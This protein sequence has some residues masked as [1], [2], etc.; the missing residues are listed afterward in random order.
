MAWSRSFCCCALSP[1]GLPLGNDQLPSVD[2]ARLFLDFYKTYGILSSI[3]IHGRLCRIGAALSF[4]A[5]SL[6]R[7]LSYKK[8][9]AMVHMSDQAGT[10]RRSR[11]V[12]S[13]ALSVAM[14]F[15][16]VPTQALSAARDELTLEQPETTVQPVTPVR[17]SKVT[18]PLSRRQPTTRPT[19]SLPTRARLLT[20][21]PTSLSRT[22]R[23][24]GRRRSRRPKA[25]PLLPRLR[26]M[27]MRPR[28]RRA[29][30]S[31]NRPPLTA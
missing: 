31:R 5:T 17:P 1:P 18:L 29:P 15:G 14:V 21:P 10:G 13:V 23:R 8:G 9:S 30:R 28:S 2:V 25:F 12:L 20:T 26:H 6:L 19:P 27:R 11:L 16:S 3:C 7:G 24:R 4:E 22:H